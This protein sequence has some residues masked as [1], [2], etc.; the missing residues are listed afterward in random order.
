[1]ARDIVRQLGGEISLVGDGP[2]ATFRIEL[3]AA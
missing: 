1:L 2:G 3:P